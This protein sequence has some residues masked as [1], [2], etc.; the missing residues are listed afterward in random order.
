MRNL[1]A[2]D[3]AGG[4][5]VHL[6]SGTAGLVAALYLGRRRGYGQVQLCGHSVPLILLG[7][8]LLWFGWFGFNAG[9]SLAANGLAANAFLVTN[10]AA[11][12]ASV[13]WVMME[14]LRG[15]RP[16]LT[17]AC[18]GAV[19]GLISITP[20][21]GFVG[22]LSAL[23]IG[24]VG[25]VLCYTAIAV[26]KARMGYDD[27][28][29]A[30]G[31]HGVGGMWGALATGLFASTSINSAGANGLLF[32]NPGQVVLQL[33]SILGTLVYVGLGT[34][35]LLFVVDRVLGLRVAPHVEDE[36]LDRY[37]H[38]EDAYPETVLAHS[39]ETLFGSAAASKLSRETRATAG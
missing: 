23:A 2:L 3:F 22:P 28:L 34:L 10:T 32:G 13:A 25:G 7:T 39:I 24:L 9:S 31:A 35:V 26:V 1:G 38:G 29:D 14:G 11:A 17:G 12:A 27:A 30:F 8:G 33:V 36:G 5:V 18:T 21:A 4:T 20:A 19:V 6:S 16:T 15:H 37:L